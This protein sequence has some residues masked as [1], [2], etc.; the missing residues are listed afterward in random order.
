MKKIVIL[1]AALSLSTP[2]V[3]APNAKELGLR[4]SLCAYQALPRFD[5]G[6]V[7]ARVVA[8]LAVQSCPQQ[9]AGLRNGLRQTISRFADPDSPGGQ[10]LT[11]QHLSKLLANADDVMANEVTKR[12]LSK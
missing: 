10:R 6:K 7:P 1:L 2:L 5:N 4:L 3:A 9:I 12:R 8:H 11:E